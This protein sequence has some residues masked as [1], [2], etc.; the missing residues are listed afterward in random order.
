MGTLIVLRFLFLRA[1]A[2]SRLQRENTTHTS[3]LEACN[4]K[5]HIKGG[6]IGGMYRVNGKF[7]ITAREYHPYIS[8]GGL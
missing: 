4:G 2:D 1:T 6:T 3:A 8:I 5:F 7:A